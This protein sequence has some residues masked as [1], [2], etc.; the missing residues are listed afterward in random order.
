MLHVQGAW[1]PGETTVGLNGEQSGGGC[2]LSPS[3]VHKGALWEKASPQEPHSTP[4]AITME[5]R[6]AV[7]MPQAVGGG[8][9]CLET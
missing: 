6:S 2:G 3:R 9:L 1:R 5:F 8:S 7:T 4:V